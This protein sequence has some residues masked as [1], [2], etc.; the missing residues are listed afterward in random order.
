[1]KD[2]SREGDT[3]SELNF[4]KLNQTVTMPMNFTRD[5]TR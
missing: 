4:K 1:M 2:K 3:S 5:N